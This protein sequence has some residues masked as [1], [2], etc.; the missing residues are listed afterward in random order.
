MNY[1]NYIYELFK[2]NNICDDTYILRYAIKTTIEEAGNLFCPDRRKLNELIK[3]KFN[4]EE[5]V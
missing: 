5:I 4:L 1:I 3:E 2:R